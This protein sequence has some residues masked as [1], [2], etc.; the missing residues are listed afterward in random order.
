MVDS[1]KVSMDCV[2]QSSHQN[3][4]EHHED[5]FTS[6]NIEDS[7][8]SHD[9]A[10]VQA[11]PLSPRS[12]SQERGESARG[13]PA[14]EDKE[15]DPDG[16][17]INDT[18]NRPHVN[19]VTAQMN[20]EGVM[21]M[22]RFVLYETSNY[23]YIVGSDMCKKFYR[24]LKIDR[25]SN[26]GELDITDDDI[27]YTAKE[28]KQIL[29]AID[30]GNRATGGVKVKCEEFWGLL[31]FVRF[32]GSYY[33]VYITRRA[34]V[35]VLGG[36]FIERI[37]ATEMIQLATVPA[38]RATLDREVEEKRLI[39]VFH[40]VDLSKGFYFS[41]SYDITRPLQHNMKQQRESLL[42]GDLGR[43]YDQND[44]FV[45]N[46]HLLGP[47]KVAMKN[48]FDWCVSIIHGYMDQREISIFWGISI[49]ITIIGRRSRHFAGARYLKRG[50]NDLGHVANDVETEQIVSRAGNTSFHAPGP[51]L[52]AS[53]EYTS[54]VQHRGSIP[55]YWT[56]DSS[57]A[58]AKPDI[59][60]NVVDPFFTAA[61]LHFDNLFER[62][63][64]PIYVLNLIKARERQPRESKLLDE[65]TAALKYL[66]QFLPRGKK[67]HYHTFDMS[68]ASKNKELDVIG[69]LEILAEEAL[70]LTNFFHNGV[71][72]ARGLKLQAGVVRTNCIDC[73]DRTNAAQFVIAKKALAIQLQ[74]LGVIEYA[75][76]D[77]D[78]DLVNMLTDMWHDH[79]DT[80]ALQYAGSHLVNNMTTYRRTGEWTSHTRDMVENVKRFVGNN[81]LDRQRQDSFN[82]FLGTYT[83]DHG[84]PLLWEMPTDYFLHHANPRSMFGRSRPS[85]RHWYTDEYLENGEFPRTLEPDE[86][87]D[88]GLQFFD[89]YWTEYYRPSMLSTLK[90]MFAFKMQSNISPTA[91]Q[92]PS[93]SKIDISP[94]KVRSRHEHEATEKDKVGQNK[95]KG[96]KVVAPSEEDGNSVYGSSIDARIAPL[97]TGAMPNPQALGNWINA[98]QQIHDAR[99]KYT[100][101]IKDS[102]WEKASKTPIV[103]EMPSMTDQ[104]NTQ[105]HEPTKQ[106][107]AVQSFTQ[108]VEKSLAPQVTQ[109]EL[110]EYKHYIDH[111]LT[112]PLVT[113]TATDYHQ[114][115]LEFL[116]Y[117]AR[118]EAIATSWRDDLTA[119]TEDDKGLSLTVEQRAELSIEQYE[120]FVRLEGADGVL[121]VT[122]D[123]TASKRY[124]TYKQW[125]KGK[126][127]FKQ[128]FVVGGELV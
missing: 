78:T 64:T 96:V 102:S 46:H 111:P 24:M 29:N 45:W 74:A 39:S 17:D 53:P 101:I 28:T 81:F 67:L 76:L 116:D 114:T 126:S 2:G 51:Y 3:G 8:I 10:A 97:Q 103:P 22:H 34:H 120:E 125:L 54:Y 59:H 5:T 50:A 106:E 108:M 37:E 80:I 71:D 113:S 69:S 77:Y 33:M 124:K 62:Y 66:N 107:L 92:Y 52:F 93:T 63:G 47:A 14:K 90:G 40:G 49:Y 128:K 58:S 68:R 122:E 21:K 83:Y 119:T 42:R 73:L 95:R 15:Y 32:T 23:Y 112:I 35:A 87:F 117:L 85:Y 121:D 13:E 104:A 55:L 91:A 31:G 109:T 99:K 1:G 12:Q 57:V 75:G 123:D 65:Y 30:D 36:H 127:L 18:P 118:N 89:D 16:L 38:T 26:S 7:T 19:P 98:H 4:D 27:V 88:R 84:G 43:S 86:L 94:F 115:P 79:G 56:Q 105:P 82:L 20:A 11:S 6:E 110:D 61:A 48:P 72:E 41:S 70:Q 9:D 100:G 60:L 44:M 25:T